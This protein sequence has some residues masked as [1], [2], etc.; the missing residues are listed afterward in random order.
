MQVRYDFNY[1]SYA[2][3][4]V[5]TLSLLD[6]LLSLLNLTAIFRDYHKL[7]QERK[8]EEEEEEEEEENEIEM[9]SLTPSSSS[10]EEVE[11]VSFWAGENRK[12]NEEGEIKAANVE[13]ELCVMETG[14]EKA[15]RREK[16]NVRG[17]RVGQEDDERR[18]Q[19][20]QQKRQECGDVKTEEEENIRKGEK[21][22]PYE[23]EMVREKEIE[24]EKM[25]EIEEVE[26]EK[27]TKVEKGVT[28]EKEKEKEEK[29][30]EEK[31]GEKPEED[32]IKRK[33]EE[34]EIK[35]KSVEDEKEEEKEVENTEMVRKLLNSFVGEEKVP[36]SR[37]R[38]TVDSDEEEE[39]METCMANDGGD[40]KTV[41]T[42]EQTESE[43]LT[44]EQTEEQTESEELAKEMTVEL[45]EELPKE[46]AWAMNVWEEEEMNEKQEMKVE[47]EE[48]KCVDLK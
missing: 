11:I 36:L 15:A 1:I 21:E 2:F 43:E 12:A 37:E 28:D 47:R 25:E 48:E 34:D 32:D 27:E 30:G 24:E 10:E 23:E 38:K 29:I 33:M 26:K 40:K 4:Y 35:K 14:E 20:L 18:L 5:G 22:E 45:T 39:Q 16:K 6:L 3:K 13:M 41:L 17:E 44:E 46:V 8:E 42:E 31:K 19:E 7:E 9:K